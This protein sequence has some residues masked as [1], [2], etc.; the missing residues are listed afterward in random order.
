MAN[1]RRLP[2]RLR[3]HP[4]HGASRREG[5]GA[6]LLAIDAEGNL[7]EGGWETAEGGRRHHLRL[8]HLHGQRQLAVQ[9]VRR[10]VSS[11]PWFAQEWKDKLFGGFTNS[12]SMNGDKFRARA[13]DAVHAGDAA[14]HAVGEPRPDA[15]QHQGG[16]SAT[17]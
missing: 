6:E 9:E 8:A 12:A 11:K 7:P 1:S 3:P 2:F 13:D 14:R 4:A 10:R 16:A 5:A 15:G 17:T